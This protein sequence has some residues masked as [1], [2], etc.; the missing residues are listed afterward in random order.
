MRRVA[1]G[2]VRPSP[3]PMSPPERYHDRSDRSPCSDSSRTTNRVQTRPSAASDSASSSASCLA[4]N[5]T[6]PDWASGSSSTW[7]SRRSGAGSVVL[8]GRTSAPDARR[9]A[10]TPGFPKRPRTSVTESAERSPRRR[11]AQPREQL[12]QFRLG[13]TQRLQPADRQPA[14]NGPIH[15]RRR[16]P[17]ADRRT[18]GALRRWMRIGHRR[19]RHPTPPHRSGN[20]WPRRRRDVRP[21]RHRPPK[22]RDGPRASR[23]IQPGSITSRRGD[24]SATARTTGSNSRA[25]DRCHGRSARCRGQRLC[26]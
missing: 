4:M 3:A 20:A 15:R 6:A 12:D 11:G 25:S 7:S 16:P 10:W 24:R 9:W 14:Q 8:D 26:A 5:T 19:S 17:A 22:Y 23:L 1:I 18:A 2:P 21:P 13:L